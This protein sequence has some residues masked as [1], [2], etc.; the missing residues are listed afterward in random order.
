MSLKTKTLTIIGGT[1]IG[2]VAVLYLATRFLILR[3]FASLEERDTR[4]NL[5]RVLDTLRDDLTALD[6][7]CRGSANNSLQ[8]ST[9]H[10]DR[11]DRKR[12]HTV[13]V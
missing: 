5:E 3:S 10:R 2:L 1:A 6:N 13:G 12:I 7:T 11:P 4:Q 9:N 8:L